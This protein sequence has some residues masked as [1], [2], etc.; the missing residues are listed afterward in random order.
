MLDISKVNHGTVLIANRIHSRD[1]MN[2]FQRN[3]EFSSD[4]MFNTL[5]N[6]LEEISLNV[7]VC[8]QISKNLKKNT[9]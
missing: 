6:A 1:N 8:L 9:E 2:R 3:L 5:K 4:T 7:V